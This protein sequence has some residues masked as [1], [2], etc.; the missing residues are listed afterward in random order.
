[1][2]GDA[3]RSDLLDKNEIEDAISSKS[4]PAEPKLLRTA[5]IYTWNRSRTSLTNP[6]TNILG[7]AIGKKGGIKG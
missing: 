6:K 3:C 2:R 1:L 7:I 4:S 5:T